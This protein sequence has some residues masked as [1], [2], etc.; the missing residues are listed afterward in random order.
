MA[1]TA[2]KIWMDGELV[3]FADAKIHVL[4]HTLHYGLGAFEGIRC[5]QR[6]DGRRAIFRLSE[7][8]KR[9]FETSHIATIDVP[10]KAAELENACAETVRANGFQSC[11]IRPVVFLGHGEMGLGALSNKVRVAI[12]AW[13]WDSY[14]GEEGIRDGIRAKVSSFNRHSVNSSMVKGKINGQYVNSILAKREVMA[15]GYKEAIMLDGEGYVSEASGENIFVV[16]DGEIYTTPQGSSILSGITRHTILTLARER[17]YSI[18]EQ[19][20]TR[21]VMYV[22]DEVFMTGTAAELTPV[23][24]VDNRTIGTGKPGPITTELQTAYFDQVKGSAMDH[25]E[26][27]TFVE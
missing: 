6:A 7:H 24:E 20:F 14:L 10:W 19:R 23:R 25:L 26:W 5:Y 12:I 1:I 21:D 11:Y 15:M 17:G 4:S 22:A 27:L 18:T 13:A 9:L 3:A 2:D 16:K 8:I